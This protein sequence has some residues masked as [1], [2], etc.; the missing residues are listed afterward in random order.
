[1]G[2]WDLWFKTI[3]VHQGLITARVSCD[4][5]PRNFKQDTVAC[6]FGVRNNARFYRGFP[7][8][9]E[10]R[11]RSLTRV[12][13]PFRNPDYCF[14]RGRSRKPTVL[15][16]FSCGDGKNKTL[17]C[18]INPQVARPLQNSRKQANPYSVNRFEPDYL[19]RMRK[20]SVSCPGVARNSE[21]RV[22][23]Q[24]GLL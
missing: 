7:R 17:P 18:L 21:F 19:L 8:T 6:V 12:T 1:M 15:F 20:G 13:N 14:P 5:R 4:T 11:H 16:F 23:C 9:C 3:E 24:C 22:R 10:T 2:T